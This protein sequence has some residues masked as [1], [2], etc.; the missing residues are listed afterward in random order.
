MEENI[1]KAIDEAK[2]LNLSILELMK[3]RGNFNSIEEAQEFKEKYRQPVELDC[4]IELLEEFTEQLEEKNTPSEVKEIVCRLE[5]RKATAVFRIVK[6]EEGKHLY[7]FMKHKRFKD[8]LIVSVLLRNEPQEQLIDLINSINRLKTNITDTDKL[9]EY[10]FNTKTKRD[11]QRL[12]NQLRWYKK[13]IEK[14]PE[15]KETIEKAMEDTKKEIEEV[16]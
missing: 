5:P 3:E 16:E 6:T 10:W 12:K 9:V 2:I 14:Y 7:K 15:Y 11:I 4:F 13:R 8:D 1:I